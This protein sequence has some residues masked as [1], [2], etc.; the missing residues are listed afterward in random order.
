MRNFFRCWLVIIYSIF[1]SSG[2]L[3][4]DNGEG[5]ADIEGPLVVQRLLAST[6]LTEIEAYADI[7]AESVVDDPEVRLLIS[8]TEECQGDARRNLLWHALR[9]TRSRLARD[10]LTRVIPNASV[11]LRI[12]WIETLR[13]PAPFDIPLMV[14]VY[15]SLDGRAVSDE[16]SLEDIFAQ[17]A[18]SHWRETRVTTWYST[19]NSERYHRIQNRRAADADAAQLRFIAYLIRHGHRLEDRIAA[20]QYRGHS[21]FRGFEAENRL[22]LTQRLL[23]TAESP[24]ER[25]RLVGVVQDQ[26]PPAFFLASAE[27][28]VVRLAAIT[29]IGEWVAKQWP[30]NGGYDSLRQAYRELLPITCDRE[31]PELRDAAWRMIRQLEMRY[32]ERAISEEMRTQVEPC[33][34]E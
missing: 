20:F 31:H 23:E 10:F 2:L 29:A 15:E 6:W 11:A 9:Y 16:S 19:R 26:I 34:E 5:E 18:L 7:L 22:Q 13:N 30:G 17:F 27:A 3:A 33:L 1:A 32:R 28:A 14:A 21:W 8:H 25:A 24:E 4:A 12:Q